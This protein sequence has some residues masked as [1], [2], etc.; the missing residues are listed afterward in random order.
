MHYQ[1]CWAPTSANDGFSIYFSVLNFD[2]FSTKFCLRFHR[3]YFFVR[4]GAVYLYISTNKDTTK[5]KIINI[6]SLKL[7]FQN[8]RYTFWAHTNRSTMQQKKIQE[9]G[10][11]G[12]NKKEIAKAT[13]EIE[14]IYVYI[15]NIYREYLL[16]LQSNISGSFFQT[17]IMFVEQQLKFFHLEGSIII[18]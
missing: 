5:D 6:S 18:P 17:C 12:N 7:E 15:L 2:S 8:L 13:P 11:S 4:K 1:L 16:C 10:V 3:W 14:K 9:A